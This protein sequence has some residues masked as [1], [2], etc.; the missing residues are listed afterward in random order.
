M[1]VLNLVNLE[2]NIMVSCDKKVIWTQTVQKR[3]EFV[4]VE[5][6]HRLPEVKVP[7]GFGFVIFSAPEIFLEG[8][9]GPYAIINFPP[10]ISILIA[11]YG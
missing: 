11:P 2:R 9:E 8:E 7:T 1:A 3:L 10:S 6:G 5:P 4:P